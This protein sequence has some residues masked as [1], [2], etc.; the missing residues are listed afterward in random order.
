MTTISPNFIKEIIDEVNK[1][2]ETSTLQLKANIDESTLFNIVRSN[3]RGD[4]YINPKREI[5]RVVP[6][7]VTQIKRAIDE[8]TQKQS[9]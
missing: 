8:Y 1:K 3:I 6:I 2:I 4:Y 9:R 7:I 5:D